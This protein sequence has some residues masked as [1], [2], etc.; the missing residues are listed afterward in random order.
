MASLLMASLL[1]CAVSLQ[2]SLRNMSE[3]GRDERDAD[4]FPGELILGT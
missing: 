4:Y 2:L 1:R 3:N